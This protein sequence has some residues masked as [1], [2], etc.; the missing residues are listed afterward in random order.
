MHSE[1]ARLT[2]SGV[3]LQHQTERSEAASEAS[4]LPEYS[5]RYMEGVDYSRIAGPPEGYG[6]LGAMSRA[7]R[8]W[9]ERG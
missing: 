1:D 7:S 8:G 5:A 2:N 6:N 3:H 9:G 4:E